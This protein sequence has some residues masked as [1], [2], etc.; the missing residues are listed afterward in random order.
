[1]QKIVTI[2]FLYFFHSLT[3]MFTRRA[4]EKPRGRERSSEW[5]GVEAARKNL[6]RMI[7]CW[8]RAMTWSRSTRWRLNSARRWTS[9][10]S[11]INSTCNSRCTC[12]HRHRHSSRTISHLTSKTSTTKCNRRP[13]R[14][15]N[16]QQKT[17]C[18]SSNRTSE[19]KVK[20]LKSVFDTYVDIVDAHTHTW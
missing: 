8:R 11:T 19:R 1:M 16:S 6:E 12:R 18:N 9:N 5:V 10:K 3:Q 7:R 14:L 4:K 20:G 13:H 15:S 2:L 17:Q